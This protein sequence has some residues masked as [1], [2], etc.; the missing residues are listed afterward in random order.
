MFSDVKLRT[1]VARR[2]SKRESAL[3]LLLKLLTD[4][5]TR[6][7]KFNSSRLVSRTIDLMKNS[8]KRSAT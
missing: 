6:M 8:K 5:E 7:R 2:I 4:R 1:N 3:Y